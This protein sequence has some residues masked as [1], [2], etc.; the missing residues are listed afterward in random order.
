MIRAKALTKYY[1]S[2]PALDRL[3]LEIP[4]SAVYAILLFTLAVSLF[5]DKD[6]LWA[7]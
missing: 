4:D 7:E 3:T 2:T 6:V 1:K 5:R